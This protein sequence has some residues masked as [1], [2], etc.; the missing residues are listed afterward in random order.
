MKCLGGISA[1]ELFS[2]CVFYFVEICRRRER[3]PGRIGGE[4]MSKGNETG[5]KGKRLRAAVL[6]EG[7]LFIDHKVA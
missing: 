3:Q 4:K 6:L 7:D 1:F 2:I 5:N